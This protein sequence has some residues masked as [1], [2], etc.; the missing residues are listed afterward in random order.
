MVPELSA[1]GVGSRDPPGGGEGAQCN[2]V[3]NVNDRR[4]QK[5]GA[6]EMFQ[7]GRGLEYVN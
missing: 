4:S 1:G 6:R 2:D 3:S 7:V 5:S